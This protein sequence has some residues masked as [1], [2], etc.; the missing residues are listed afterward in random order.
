M[1]TNGGG[2]RQTQ[3]KST[4]KKQTIKLRDARESVERLV[5]KRELVGGGGARGGEGLNARCGGA[6]TA[7]KQK[8]PTGWEAVWNGRLVRKAG[9][10]V[11][12]DQNKE[13]LGE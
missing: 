11:V 5:E 8:S 12:K 6:Y 9:S 4:R 2:G 1:I 3:I 10:K 13:N 7:K